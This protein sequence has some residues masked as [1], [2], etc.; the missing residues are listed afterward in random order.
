MK[1]IRPLLHHVTLKTSRLREMV[2]WYKILVGVE[3]T[4]QDANNAWTSNDGANH[5]IAFLSVPGLEDDAAKTRHNGMHHSAFEY[6]SFDDLMSS[7]GRLQGEGILPTFCL[8]HGMTI[9]LYY[10]DPEGNHVELQS[11][12]FGDWKRSTEFMRT[13]KDFQSNPIGTFFDPEKVFQAY[14]A[15]EPFA[16]LQPAIRAGKFLPDTIPSIGLPIEAGPGEPIP[17]AT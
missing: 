4:F 11:D 15:G 17:L 12:S 14:K 6:G 2:D 13:S 9:S 10:R 7:Y 16:T 1:V 5:R 8:D 3:V